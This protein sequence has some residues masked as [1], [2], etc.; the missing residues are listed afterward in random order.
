LSSVQSD[1]AHKEKMKADA[2]A[3]KDAASKLKGGKK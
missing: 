2:K 1:L 3:L